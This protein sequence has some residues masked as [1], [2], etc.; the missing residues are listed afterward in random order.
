MAVQT[1][2]PD[3]KAKTIFITSTRMEKAKG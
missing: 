1:A 2:V 3:T